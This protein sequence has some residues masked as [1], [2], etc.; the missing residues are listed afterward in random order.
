MNMKYV[1]I[2]PKTYQKS[3]ITIL[4]CVNQVIAKCNYGIAIHGA[5][6]EET[7]GIT[8]IDGQG[9]NAPNCT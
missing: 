9:G 3:L 6:L 2:Y 8:S 5:E 1:L 4:P 7:I